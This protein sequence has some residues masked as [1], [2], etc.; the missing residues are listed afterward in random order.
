MSGRGSALARW[1]SAGRRLLINVALLLGSLAV[2]AAGVEVWARASEELRVRREMQKTEEGGKL[3]RFSP[4]LGWEKVPGSHRRVRRSEFDIELSANSHGLRGPDRGYAKPPGTQRVLLLGDSFAAG[5]YAN[6]PETVRGVLE[7]RLRQDGCGP[8]EVI[9]GGTIAY[10]TDQEYLF[11]RHEGRRYGA[12]VVVLMFYYNDLCYNGQ[13]RGPQGQGKP[14]FDIRD[15]HLVQVAEPGPPP[16]PR[17]AEEGARR[18]PERLQPWRG[19]LALRRLA[20]RT[21]DGA[22]RLH[23]LLARFGLV[24]PMSRRIDPELWVY[25]PHPDV[26]RWWK[27]TDA[28]IAALRK[29]V[30][31]DGARLAV[32]Y[33]PAFFEVHDR[34][35]TLTRERYGLG[36]RWNRERVFL[37]LQDT[38]RKLGLPLID[39]RRDLAAA[40][41]RGEHAYYREDVHWTP[42][43]HRIAALSAES[44]VRGWLRCDPGRR[45]R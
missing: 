8:V 5:Y 23:E 16:A 32:L 13:A 12:E 30:E 21:E 35:W 31:A 24:P 29:D 25:H 10:S 14:Q 9:N 43:G 40:E 20:R 37:R 17:P 36:R 4:I 38:C 34:T 18:E 42:L 15:G 39:P 45:P 11:Y 44:L 33:V 2:C 27:V 1:A 41:A 22:P 19:S 28:L 7:A 6:D 3:I 26:V